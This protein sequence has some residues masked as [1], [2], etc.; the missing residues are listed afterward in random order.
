[1]DNVYVV[2]VNPYRVCAVRTD[3]S[4]W[5]GSGPELYDTYKGALERKRSYEYG[6]IIPFNNSFLYLCKA[7]TAFEAI[8]KY[9]TMQNKDHTRRIND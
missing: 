8:G 9:W 2:V 6:D 7:K 4:V 3:Y 1:M 5:G